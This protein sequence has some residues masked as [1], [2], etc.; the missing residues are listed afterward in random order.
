MEPIE[1]VTRGEELHDL[2]LRERPDLYLHPEEVRSFLSHEYMPW[3]VCARQVVEEGGC[4]LLDEFDEY[5]RA[6]TTHLMTLN[7]YGIKDYLDGKQTWNTWDW[8]VHH[9]EACRKLDRQRA[10][11]KGF[12]EMPQPA[13]RGTVSSPAPLDQIMMR[14]HEFAVALREHPHGR[15]GFQIW[16]EYDVQY[17]LKA[18][19]KLFFEDVR[20]EEW[21][22]SHLGSSNR[23]DFLLK[24]QRIAIEVK[25]ASE[26][27]RDKHI[28]N[29]LAV[30]I[31]HYK[32]RCHTLYCL[33]YDPGNHIQNRGGLLGDLRRASVPDLKVVPYIA[34]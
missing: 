8:D 4:H 15:E 7:N 24:E 10:I 1:L 13:E 19:L 34:P 6:K 26:S 17:L 33:I 23:M 9:R 22:P 18:L 25:L 20:P 2:F 3:Y 16:D 30:D 31:Q 5:Y 21:T 32:N 11:L 14:F 29:E 12:C 27:H 28:G